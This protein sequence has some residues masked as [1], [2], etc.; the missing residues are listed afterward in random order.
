MKINGPGWWDVRQ[1]RAVQ[2]VMVDMLTMTKTAGTH[3]MLPVVMA[4]VASWIGCSVG[5]HA[6]NE[7]QSCP[8]PHA[9]YLKYDKSS[10]CMAKEFILRG[11]GG[12][13]LVCT[14]YSFPELWNK[15]LACS[16][17]SL[18]YSVRGI[19]HYEDKAVVVIVME[20]GLG[21][22]R[23]VSCRHRQ[24][25]TF[26]SFSLVVKGTSDTFADDC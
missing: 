13:L 26:H 20:H 22:N 24:S 15:A 18:F 3:N 7:L 25:L 4:S 1:S 9:H 21:M 5:R 16:T 8:H 11:A 10:L 2:R 19:V 6:W 14:P 17:F 23:L 12:L